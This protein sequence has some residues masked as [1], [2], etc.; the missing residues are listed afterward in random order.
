MTTSRSLRRRVAPAVALLAVGTAGGW[1]LRGALDKPAAPEAAQVS[2]A[3]NRPVVASGDATTE[4]TSTPNVLGLTVDQAQQV[5]LDAGYAPDGIIVSRVAAGGD[6]GLV[7]AQEPRPG[8]DVSGQLTVFVSEATTV[9]PLVGMGLDDAR[10]VLAELGV[11]ATVE[12]VYEAAAA[13]GAVLAVEPAE[14]TT[15]P[16]EVTLVVSE[17]PSAVFLT[18]LSSTDSDSCSRGSVTV[19]VETFPFSLTCTVPETDAQGSSAN[20]EY[21]INSGIAAFEATVGHQSSSD[22]VDATVMVLIDGEVVHEVVV[23]AGQPQFISVPTLGAETVEI[24][25]TRPAFEE[26][27]RV[28][29]FIGD[30]KFIGSREAVDALVAATGR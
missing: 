22:V 8:A 23:G 10:D 20:V 9:P 2:V 16:A 3:V 17:A 29:T 24:R 21:A 13:E 12:R 14:G 25:W 27:L 6:E 28:R 18:D 5:L 26:R 1:W 15:L 19:D 11:R 7:L 4:A 30:A